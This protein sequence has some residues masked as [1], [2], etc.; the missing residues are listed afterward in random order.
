MLDEKRFRQLVALI[1]ELTN[2]ESIEYTVHLSDGSSIT[3]ESADEVL[4]VQNS[5][6]RRITSIWVDTP[7]GSEPRIE[8]K[9]NYRWYLDPIEYEVA[10]SEKDVFHSD[11]KL[12]EYF[13]GVR[14][15][16]SFIIGQGLKQWIAFQAF[17]LPIVFV[18]LNWLERRLGIEPSVQNLGSGILLWFVGGMTILTVILLSL[19]ALRTSLFPNGTFALGDGVDRHHNLVRTRRFA[20]GV[21]LTLFLGA[22]GYVLYP[23]LF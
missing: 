18:T 5:K 7:F 21:I 10:G 14:Q 11:G 8:I 23:L 12:R 3:Y 9:F 1:E 22:V 2:A 16:Y 17:S 15:W 4:A 19:Y 6:E 13:S 20:G